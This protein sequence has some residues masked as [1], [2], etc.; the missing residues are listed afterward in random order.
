MKQTATFW[1]RIAERYSK[2]PISDEA[3]YRRKLEITQSHLRPDMQVLEFGCGTG[4]TALIHAAYVE[5]IRVID[6]SSRMI[7][8]ARVKAVTQNV[9]NV[10]FEH[11]TLEDL[12]VEEGSFDAILGMS[13]LHL[14]DD[15]Q[16]AIVYD[17]YG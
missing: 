1:D 16:G 14:L 9:S 5:H 4:G 11:L 15:W 8:I 3:S 10:S 7:E 17:L 13:I 12:G 6:I 2:R